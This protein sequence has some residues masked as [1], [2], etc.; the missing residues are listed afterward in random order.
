MMVRTSI[1]AFLAC[2]ISLTSGCAFNRQTVLTAS[3]GPSPSAP[4]SASPNGNLLVY[5]AVETPDP[6]DAEYSS[7]HH[8]G[9]SLFSADGARPK[10]IYN[11]AS[12]FREEPE[13]V[14]LY[15]GRYKIVALAS[16]AGTVTVTLIIEAGKTTS[17]YLDKSSPTGRLPGPDSRFVTLPDGRFVGWRATTD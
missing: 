6:A 10:Y 14:P 17:V 13:T 7:P 9:Y 3:V 8:S 4:V 1:P 12:T 16:G 11:R 2:L 5:S 15:P